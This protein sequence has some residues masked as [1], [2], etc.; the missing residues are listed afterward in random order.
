MILEKQTEAIVQQAGES[1]DSIG[2]SLD[3][4][5]AQVLMQM[6]S[7]NL[8]SD[9]IGS[10]IRECASN[11]LDSHRRCGTDKPI[12]VAFKEVAGQYEFSV[13]D[14]GIGLDADDVK[15]IIS[16]YGKS[17]KRN[18]TTELG[19]MGLGFKAPLAYSS[20]F[21]FVCRKNG[22]ER[23]YMMYEG[24]ETNTIDLLYETVT[25]EPNGVKVIVPVNHY[26]RSD[27]KDKIREQLAYFESVYF[28]VEDFD[29]NFSIMRSE[30]F[31]F[32]RIAKNDELHICLDNVYY[33]LDTQKLGLSSI[34][35]PVGL[36][37][38]LTD[39]I[40]PTPNRESIRYTKEAKDMI[41]KKISVVAEY[42]VKKYN[43]SV[44]ETEDFM[45]VIEYYNKTTRFVNVNGLNLDISPLKGF[46]NT[47][48]AKPVMKDIKF[49][50]LEKLVSDKDF[51]L[52]E[53]NVNFRINGGKFRETKHNYN[54][55]V[56]FSDIRKE[57]F[58]IYNNRLTGNMKEYL[59]FKYPSGRW[60]ND[61]YICKKIK[62]YKLG[63]PLD[64]KGTRFSEYST[65][66]D[67]LQL[68]KFPKSEWRNVIREFQY[69]QRSIISSFIKVD[70]IV[71]PQE[72]LDARK[73]TSVAI[74]G[75]ARRLK[76]KGEIVGKELK[77]LERDV[78]GKYSKQVSTIYDLAKI[79][80]EERLMVYGRAESGETMDKLFSVVNSKKVG[81]IIFSEREMKNFDQINIHN[82]M[83]IETFM[84]GE[85]KPFKRIVTAHLINKLIYA[86]RA[87]FEKS[88][89]LK[90]ISSSLTNKLE[91]LYLYRSRNY[92]SGNENIFEAMLE[93]AEA[94]KLFDTEIYS[95]YVEIKNILEKL[96]FINVLFKQFSSYGNNTEMQDIM[97]DMFKY[98]KHR[99]D[100]KRY[101][102]TIQEKVSEEILTDETIEDLCIN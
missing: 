47:P 92:I 48:I 77:P 95:T 15:N 8:Y 91:E 28:D 90:T 52:S 85:N 82:W 86:N 74:S 18:S 89:N 3:L 50:D 84:K 101:G 67:I 97:V 39:G 21:Y 1:Q 81:F 102:I 4:D 64:T 41:L 94:N 27:F 11:A 57:N 30:H 61:R 65:Y 33:P 42:F 32:S 75:G 7:K 99:I 54:K 23:K 93:V 79:H 98:Y 55:H 87:T 59:K 72:W 24:E 10:T 14:F 69:I 2:M 5:S 35:F 62:S 70:D 43:E 46:S 80:R 76:L 60:D 17:T 78:Q 45:Q 34:R 20:S 88:H 58:L 71:I 53:Y 29:N 36:R 40:F 19:M 73:K 56:R 9:S 96:P 31:Q 63:G 12:I 49:L 44:K 13:E 51:L 37:F 16:K 83:P 68:K 25:Q 22:M 26:D 38:S 6:L 100:W 66:Y